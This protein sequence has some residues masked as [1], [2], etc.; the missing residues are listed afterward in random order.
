MNGCQL[1]VQHLKEG[2]SNTMRITYTNGKGSRRISETVTTGSDKA[3]QH[4]E[5]KRR[6][7]ACYQL[8]QALG[9]G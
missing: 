5:R 3:L 4:N 8:K 2:I 6:D 1:F 7:F 9:M